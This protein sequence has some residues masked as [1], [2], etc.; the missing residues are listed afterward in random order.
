MSQAKKKTNIKASIK[1]KVREYRVMFREMYDDKDE[2]E[3]HTL[4]KESGN[5]ELVKAYC[6][7]PFKEGLSNEEISV[8]IDRVACHF[9][10]NASLTKEFMEK[11]S[12]ILKKYKGSER[13]D[14][15]LGIYREM[16]EFVMD[17]REMDVPKKRYLN[18]VDRKDIRELEE[19]KTMTTQE[20]LDHFRKGING[21]DLDQFNDL[22]KIKGRKFM[23]DLIRKNL[24]E[25]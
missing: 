4:W 24:T 19:I 5:V 12:K 1:T 18:I 10:I 22:I 9:L 16:G 20:I 11:T 13:L 23:A 7:I 2:D 21:H 8:I 3:L 15:M 6:G 14:E 25:Y 17:I